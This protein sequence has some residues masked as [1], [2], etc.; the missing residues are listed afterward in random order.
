MG[1]NPI[2]DFL[3]LALGVVVSIETGLRSPIVDQ[4]ARLRRSARMGMLRLSSARVSDHWKGQ[5][6][7]RYAVVVL[8]STFAI[9]VFVT[10][11]VMPFFLICWFVLGSF[12]AVFAM[13]VRPNVAIVLTVFTVGYFYLR[14][15][16]RSRG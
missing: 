10:M 6:A 12:D 3:W 11:S 8:A 14:A 4:I 16:A 7:R 15:W 2:G 13:L 5:A 9:L 1:M